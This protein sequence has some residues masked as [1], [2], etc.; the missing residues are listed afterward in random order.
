MGGASNF[1]IG[2]Q[3]KLFTYLQY[4]SL[5]QGNF[6]RSTKVNPFGYLL[7]RRK[8]MCVPHFSYLFS[9]Q[10]CDDVPVGIPFPCLK[11]MIQRIS[12]HLPLLLASLTLWINAFRSYSK[13]MIWSVLSWCADAHHCVYSFAY[14]FR[15]YSEWV[16]VCRCTVLCRFTCF[17]TFKL[18]TCMR[19]LLTLSVEYKNCFAF[20]WLWLN[21][22]VR[23]YLGCGFFRV[24]AYPNGLKQNNF[25]C[26]V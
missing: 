4:L 17:R 18:I 24:H 21:N 13:W 6:G 20:R 22:K 11:Y 23:T 12:R 26:Q 9:W 25:F 3:F 14:S 1:W 15:S 7:V 2:L 10:W 19:S 16:M 8:Y 5:V